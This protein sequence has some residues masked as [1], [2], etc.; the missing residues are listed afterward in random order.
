VSDTVSQKRFL[1]TSVVRPVLLGS[2]P[3]RDYFGAQFG[4]ESLYISKYVKMEFNRSFLCPILEFYFFV[5]MPVFETVGDA[6]K[7]WSNN[8]RGSLHKAIEQLFG[9]LL[10]GRRLE[11]L[12]PRDK[13]KALRAIGFYAKRLEMKQ[14]ARFK[15]IGSNSTRCARATV[16]PS[17]RGTEDL[18]AVL[19]RFLERFNDV[20]NCRKRCVVDDFVLRRYR[21]EVETYVKQAHQLSAP[22]SKTNKGFTDIANNL[23]KILTKGAEACSC[24]LCG[25]IGDAIIALEAP[26]DMRLEHTDRSF[27][28]L[29]ELI[30][31]PHHRHPS[32]LKVVQTSS[33]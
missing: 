8:F 16:R 15:D 31:Q 24:R 7:A 23:E 22:R 11:K 33:R 18:A 21:A 17:A 10:D 29:C 27:D 5:D 32:E 26:N 1:D 9:D 14:R 20:A 25:N 28:H 13:A 4:D 2:K 12:D 3:Y 19:R 6:L 30:D